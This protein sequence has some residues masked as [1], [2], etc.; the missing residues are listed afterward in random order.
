MDQNGL[1]LISQ[2]QFSDKLVK[3]IQFDPWDTHQSTKSPEIIDVYVPENE[4]C[5][6][7]GLRV[8]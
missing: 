5:V 6:C 3:V 1:N 2:V 8:A 7:S 4:L